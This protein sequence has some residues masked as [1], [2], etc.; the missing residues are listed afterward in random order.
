MAASIS[1]SLG[2]GEVPCKTQ[3]ATSAAK[4]DRI[5]N[6]AAPKVIDFALK[7]LPTIITD[8]AVRPAAGPANESYRTRR[9]ERHTDNVLQK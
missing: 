3:V 1:K 7:N 6:S 9:R 5:P 8:R 2:H 4:R